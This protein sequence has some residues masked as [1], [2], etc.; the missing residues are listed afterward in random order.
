M[1]A[2]PL[3]PRELLT[4]RGDLGKPVRDVGAVWEAHD[5]VLVIRN[6]PPKRAD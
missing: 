1:T 2:P 4:E 3:V 6:A 5:V